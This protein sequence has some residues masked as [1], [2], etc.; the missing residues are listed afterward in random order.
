MGSPGQMLVVVFGIYIFEDIGE[1]EQRFI[2]AQSEIVMCRF[3]VGLLQ[4]VCCLQGSIRLE[5]GEIV[6]VLVGG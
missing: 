4:H 1:M 2:C 3:L 6:C 5:D